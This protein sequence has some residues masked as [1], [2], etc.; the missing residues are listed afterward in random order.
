MHRRAAHGEPAA[1]V[2]LTPRRHE[3]PTLAAEERARDRARCLGDRLGDTFRHD[4]S[5]VLAGA[6]PEV[7]DPVGRPHHL[8]VVL[9]D[10]NGVAHV[11]KLLERVDEPPVVALVEPDRR[12]VE[13]VENA[14]ELRPDLRRKPQPLRLTA[15]QGLGGTVEL[16]VA[17]TDVLEERE[18]LAY[19]LEDPPADQLFGL[20]QPELVDEAQC[21][22]NGHLP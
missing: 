2:V 7:D 12:L 13:D 15:R 14:D 5:P 22:C 16:E 21:P 4:L 6:G 17:D 20:R 18:P 11:A 9:D 8:L 10:E 3:D 19:L 1:L